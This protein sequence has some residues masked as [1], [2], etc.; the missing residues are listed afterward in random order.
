[1][2]NEK[3]KIALKNLARENL[4]ENIHEITNS[5]YKQVKRDIV[6][7]EFNL[8]ERIMNSPMTKYVVAA[9]VLLIVVFAGA[10]IFKPLGKTEI[11][12]S[13]QQPSIQKPILADAQQAADPELESWPQTGELTQNQLAEGVEKI[14]E[15]FAKGDVDGLAAVLSIPEAKYEEKIIAA[16]F[17]AQIGDV[18]VIGALEEL[19][20]QWQGSEAEN[21]FAIAVTK[22]QNRESEKNELIP[23]AQVPDKPAKESE[24]NEPVAP[25]V[26]E[27]QETAAEKIDLK[28][29]LQ[30]GQK[31]E[32]KI[33]IDQKIAQTLMGQEQK[34]NQKMS[35][36]IISEVL[37]VDP[38]GAIALKTMYNQVKFKMDGPMGQIEYDSNSNNIPTDINNPQA[39]MMADMWSAMVG[40]SFIMDITPR[41]NIIGVRDFDKMW[42]RMMEKMAGDDPNLAQM[43]KKM[44]KNFVSED[45]L[46]ETGGDTMIKFLDE[47]VA[48]GD[49]WH[50]AINIDVGFPMEIDVTYMLKERKDGIAFIDVMSK[51]DIGDYDSKL[52]EVEDMQMNM[53]LSGTRTGTAE[54]DE[55]TGW[56]IKG[57]TNQNFS[58]VV[59]I[60]PNQHMPNGMSIPMTIQTTSTVESMQIE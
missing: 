33:S 51:M 19:S 57:E 9:A 52:V 31:F 55:E 27:T 35:F 11:V 10:Q 56:I 22:I 7:I 20:R 16:N 5:V 3:I 4:P 17:L 1:M 47:P 13:I 49:L 29:N 39:K 36:G 28:L 54:V 8:W 14:K 21:P 42:E 15:M 24:I 53:Q 26:P 18:R 34:T 59:K 23:E 2:I 12:E 45:T 60:L 44:M 37:A 58:G 25:A 41:C 32:T 46:K 6:K 48:I 40:E 43:M 30:Q 50:D 38:N